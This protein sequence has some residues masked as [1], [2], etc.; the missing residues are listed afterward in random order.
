MRKARKAELDIIS[1]V[2]NLNRCDNSNSEDGYSEDFKDD[3]NQP[4]YPCP[5]CTSCFT[6]SEDL[7]VRKLLKIKLNNYYLF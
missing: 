3:T 7:K 2:N 6:T 1:N 5:D 4:I